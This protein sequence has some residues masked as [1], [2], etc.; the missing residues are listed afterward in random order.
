[1]KKWMMVAF[2]ISALSALVSAAPL[3]ACST[4]GAN[5]LIS[6][7]PAG[8]CIASGNIS[9]ANGESNVEAAILAWTG[10]SRQIQMIHDTVTATDTLVVDFTNQFAGTF[11]APSPVVYVTVKAG[12]TFSIYQLNPASTT[13]SFSSS[14]IE[15]QNGQTQ[16]ISHVVLWGTEAPPPPRT[17]VPEPSTYALM[18][19]ALLALGFARRRK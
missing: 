9:G 19:G 13:G 10:I 16:A 15:N 11:T 18:G 14:G 8:V 17:E 6:A 3:P 4:G 12:N 2:G 5:S 1:M 7:G